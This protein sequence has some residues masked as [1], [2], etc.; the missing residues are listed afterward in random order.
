M[1]R[2]I[3]WHI[4]LVILLSY[5]HE[6]YESDNYYSSYLHIS[7]NYF[8]SLG[9]DTEIYRTFC[10]IKAL[11]CYQ[12][13][14]GL[15]SFTG[16]MG[17]A[18][19]NLEDDTGDCQNYLC[20]QW[21]TSTIYNGCVYTAGILDLYCYNLSVW[22]HF[23]QFGLQST[24]GTLWELQEASGKEFRCFSVYWRA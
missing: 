6:C 1:F 12:I 13:C 5:Y 3:L 21:F 8:L 9:W 17:I 11:S 4:L 16:C 18:M 24:S 7:C 19:L 14:S 22:K 20:L 10:K 23:V 15:L 2:L